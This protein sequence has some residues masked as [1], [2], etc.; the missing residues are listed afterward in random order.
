MI[1]NMTLYNTFLVGAVEYKKC[2]I[3]NVAEGSRGDRRGGGA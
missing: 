1:L 2:F 3:L